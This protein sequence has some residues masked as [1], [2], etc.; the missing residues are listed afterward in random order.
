MTHFIDVEE[1]VLDEEVDVTE[2]RFDAVCEECGAITRFTTS[3]EQ[4]LGSRFE[5]H[6]YR[7]N[8]GQFPGVGE[9]ACFRVVDLS[10][11]PDTKPNQAVSPPVYTADESD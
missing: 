6:C 7:C 10:P 2:S 4:T 3:G 8:S 11:D 1:I 5:R 9:T